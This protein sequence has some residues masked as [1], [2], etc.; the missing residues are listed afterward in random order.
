MLVSMRIYRVLLHGVLGVNSGR[1]GMHRHG[2]ALHHIGK[3]QFL[4]LN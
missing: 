3:M 1:L 2:D 4:P